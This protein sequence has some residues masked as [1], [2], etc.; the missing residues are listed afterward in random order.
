MR[1]ALVDI[2]IKIP[3]DIYEELVRRA[4][5]IGASVKTYIRT[6]LERHVS[7]TREEI[8]DLESK[9]V[10]LILRLQHI[11]LEELSVLKQVVFEI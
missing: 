7:K 10:D 8:S 11:V 3:K 2:N 9:E 4:R 1:L 6:L 5:I